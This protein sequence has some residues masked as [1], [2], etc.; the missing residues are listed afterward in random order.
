MAYS[1]RHPEASKLFRD[2]IEKQSNAGGQGD[3]FS[4]WYSFACVAVAANHTDDALLYLREALNRG[5]RGADGLMADN[6]L[7][8]LRDNPHFREIIGEL[9]PPR[10][11]VQTQQCEAASLIPS[12]FIHQVDHA[13]RF[14]DSR[15]KGLRS[16]PGYPESKFKHS[17]RSVFV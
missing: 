13:R 16:Y 7:K 11:K 5:Y 17:L 14:D 15:D 9:K 6:N 3:Y 2:V 12:R 4:V 10:T 8:N 1:H